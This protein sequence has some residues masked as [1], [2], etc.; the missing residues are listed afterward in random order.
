LA[1]IKPLLLAL[2]LALAVYGL[3]ACGGGGSG[4]SPQKVID[5]TFSGQ[6]N[7]TSG[8]IDIALTVKATGSQGGSFDIKLGGPFESH[9][10]QFPKFDFKASLSGSGSG[11]S[12]SFT[13][14]LLST[15][16][17]AFINYQGTSY[18][19]DDNTFNQF[20]SQ[21]EAQAANAKGKSAS[22][23]PFARL[24]VHPKEWL[25]NLKNEGTESVGGV[26]TIHISGDGDI[27]KVVADLKRILGAAGSLGLPAGGSLPSAGQLDL[28]TKAIKSA[29]FDL[30]TGKDDKIIRKLATNLVIEPPAGSGGPS[31]IDLNF[32][33]TLTDINKPQTVTAPSSSK[34]LTDLLGRFNIGGLGA[35]TGA[36]A[37]GSPGAGPSS[38]Q[39]QKYLQCLQNAK[40]QSAIAGCAK[41]LQ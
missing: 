8:K 4:E 18:K 17:S 15:G 40:D 20:K 33:I 30:F 6:K 11:Q 25:T 16:D 10:K 3:A 13:G 28:V 23:N 29:H 34:P 36:G 41:A 2:A 9:P 38:T 35:A 24:G 22:S 12:L 26:D 1:R 27:N 32:S 21:Y 5:A 19:V 7:V 37:G 39:S 31:R 14:G